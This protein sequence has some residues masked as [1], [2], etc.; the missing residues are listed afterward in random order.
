[1]WPPALPPSADN[2]FTVNIVLGPR[3]LRGGNEQK[4]KKSS[5]PGEG[6][7]QQLCIFQCKKQALCLPASNAKT[8]NPLLWLLGWMRFHLGFLGTCILSVIVKFFRCGSETILR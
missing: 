4:S 5:E 8:T 2:G 6:R 1:M 3:S 7:E